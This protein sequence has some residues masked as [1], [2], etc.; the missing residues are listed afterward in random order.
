MTGVTHRVG[1]TE[2][3]VMGSL[4]HG[5]PGGD[6][7]R[8]SPSWGHP[9][10]APDTVTDQGHPSLPALQ[11]HGGDSA[12]PSKLG[13]NGDPP[14]HS[15]PSLGDAKQSCHGNRLGRCGSSC[16]LKVG[17]EK[18]GGGGTHVGGK[19]GSTP[20]KRGTPDPSVGQLL[21][22]PPHQLL[23]IGWTPL[24]IFLGVLLCLGGESW[25]SSTHGNMRDPSPTLGPL[26]VQPSWALG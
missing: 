2:R 18:I 22:I 23:C 16:G 14:P 11:P 26:P 7:P 15:P 24:P 13:P 19:L 20:P 6:F 12:V 10:P 21:P 5:G 9:T 3:P 1:D 8:L 25:W 4:P 17:R